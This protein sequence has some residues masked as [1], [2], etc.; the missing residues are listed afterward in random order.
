MTDQGKAIIFSAPSG[1]GKTTIVRHL[2]SQ[3]DNL[4]FSV[5]ATSR[6]RRGDEQ[7]GIDYHFLSP[8][9]FKARVATNDFVEWEEVYK[10]HMYGTLKSEISSVWESG[11]HVIF[12]VDVVGGMNLKKFFG[13]KALAIFVKPPSLGHL[14]ARLE[15]RKTETPE[16]IA[17]RMAKSEKEMAY[18]EHFDYVLL[19]DVLDRSCEEAMQAVGSFLA[20]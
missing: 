18:A 19:N 10:D 15:A 7:D 13:D 9:E 14:R 16:K 11:N 1:A 4:K 3:I 5:S 17:L 6:Q 2:L 20:S 8:E 12:D